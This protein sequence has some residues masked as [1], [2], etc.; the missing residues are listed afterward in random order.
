DLVSGYKQKRY[1]PWHKVYPSRIFNRMLSSLSG[2]H[3]HD[4]NCGFKCYRAEVTKAITLYGSMHRMVPVLASMEGFQVGEIVVQH[5]PRR[6][7]VS[8]YGTR[9]M[10]NGFLDMLTVTFLKYFRESPLHVFGR[11]ALLCVLV[12]VS[13]LVLA[14]ALELL[15]IPQVIL[16]ILG[17]N[18][19]VVSLPVLATGFVSELII[20]GK[21]GNRYDIPLALDTYNI[22]NPSDTTTTTSFVPMLVAGSP[23]ISAQ[24]PAKVLL[25]EDD[26]ISRKMIRLMLK[27]TDTTLVEALDGQEGL[28][29]LTPEIDIVILD[30]NMPKMDGI[31]FLSEM[32]RRGIRSKVIVQTASSKV[33]FAIQAMK[34]GAFDYIT[35]P[36][37]RD[38]LLGS[39]QKARKVAA[40]TDTYDNLINPAS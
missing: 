38:Q 16:S 8:K 7:G 25:V 32:R 30:V 27:N 31:A 22:R 14:T 39:I 40:L 1:D 37:T 15:L 4:H 2:V 10:L 26:A 23:E 13:T 34:L 18:I 19:L 6:F 3:L 36:F 33:D 17:G 11:I 20:S 35:K 9:R 29:L 28:D 5:H 21:R 24:G 12:G